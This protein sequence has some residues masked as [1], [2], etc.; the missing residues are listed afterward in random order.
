MA[1]WIPG[2]SVQDEPT[3][4]PV[5]PTSHAIVG[6]DVQI[7]DEIALSTLSDRQE[8]VLSSLFVVSACLSIVGS[9]T[10]V[11]KVLRNRSVAS[12]YDRLLFGL[13]VADIVASTT[14]AMWP[15]LLPDES[16]K[17]IW[18]VGNDAT[19]NLLGFLT[20]LSFAAMM[21]NGVLSYYYLLTIRFG[22]KQQRMARIEHWMH[23][24]AICFP[25]VTASLGA[26]FGVYHE[27]DVGFGSWTNNYPEGCEGDECTAH[28]W[29]YTFGLIPIGFTFGSL[30]VNNIIIYRYVRRILH[31]TPAPR[32]LMASN[33]FA[34]E[35]VSPEATKAKQVDESRQ[36]HIKE[37]AIQGFLYVGAFF[38]SYWSPI[39][40]R[41]L[42]HLILTLDDSSLYP[43]LVLQSIGLPLQGFFNMLVYNRQNYK[44]LRAANPT[45]TSIAA[46]WT[47]CFDARIPSRLTEDVTSIHGGSTLDGNVTCGKED[48]QPSH[49]STAAT[50]LCN[51]SPYFREHP[52][53]YFNACAQV[54]ASS[55][56]GP[57]SLPGE[58]SAIVSNTTLPVVEEEGEEDGT[59]RVPL[60]VS[61]LRNMERR[62]SSANTIPES[63]LLMSEDTKEADAVILGPS[64]DNDTTILD[65]T[66]IP[67]NLLHLGHAQLIPVTRSFRIRMDGAVELEEKQEDTC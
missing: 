51:G 36:K 40:L 14:Y 7:E 10:I 22:W 12:P 3:M 57:A 39:V 25:L 26:A 32:D 6:L 8:R 41:V 61:S 13:S 62:R 30:V 53:E 45:M 46:L 27:L 55:C 9:A 11:R 66:I 29:G 56:S 19:C 54:L 50:S 16:S 4:A 38:F 64:L 59:T 24:F 63:S 67:S 47:S 60:R 2:T 35:N 49:T 37:V 1:E 48:E 20:Q 31:A 18:A 28:I 21:Y 43:L 42:E 15:F 33:D 44:R 58:R 52:L 34:V 65:T 5:P 23:F 17:R